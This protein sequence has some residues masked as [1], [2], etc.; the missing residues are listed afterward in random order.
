[1]IRK[2]KVDVINGGQASLVSMETHPEKNLINNLLNLSIKKKN[3][4]KKI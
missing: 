1:M 4:S 2:I 3:S